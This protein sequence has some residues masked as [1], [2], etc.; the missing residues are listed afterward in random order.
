MCVTHMEPKKPQPSR[1]DDSKRNDRVLQLTEMGLTHAQVG[2]KP[3][4]ARVHLTHGG[5][6]RPMR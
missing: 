5:D 1:G 2:A 3:T 4:D 6:L